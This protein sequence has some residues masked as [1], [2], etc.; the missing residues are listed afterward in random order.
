[1]GEDRHADLETHSFYKMKSIIVDREGVREKNRVNRR[2]RERTDRERK[3]GPTESTEA[4]GLL[5]TSDSSQRQNRHLAMVLHLRFK[6]SRE[7]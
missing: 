1:M 5:L 2:K 6:L 3:T 7:N 4:S